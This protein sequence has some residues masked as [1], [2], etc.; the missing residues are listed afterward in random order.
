MHQARL[1]SLWESIASTVLGFGISMVAQWFFLPLLGVPISLPQNLAFAVIM[2]A[3]SVGRGYVVRRL[4]EKARISLRLSPFILAVI[5]E[6]QRQIDEEG[7]TIEHDDIEHKHGDLA[8]HGAVYVLNAVSLGPN[9]E[10]AEFFGAPAPEQ[11]LWART[12][13]KPDGY[14][15]DLVKGAALI[16]ADGEKCDRQRKPGHASNNNAGPAAAPGS[17]LPMFD[18]RARAS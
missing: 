9:A 8:R 1:Q 5:A 18:K 11:W 10:R 12:W 3:I 14:R 13:W 17:T 7:W 15:R 16:V 2:T 6:R 4:F